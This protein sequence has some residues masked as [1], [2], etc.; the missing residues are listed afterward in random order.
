MDHNVASNVE[1]S[2]VCN[3]KI[4]CQNKQKKENYKIVFSKGA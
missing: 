1:E 2:S 3:R 4:E